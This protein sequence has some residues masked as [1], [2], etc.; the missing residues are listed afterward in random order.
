MLGFIG[1]YIEAHTYTHVHASDVKNKSRNGI[2][3]H[4][5]GGGVHTA[6]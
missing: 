4:K 1:M 2:E 3:S 5:R 6:S